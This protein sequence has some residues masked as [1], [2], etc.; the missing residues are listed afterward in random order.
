MTK[1]CKDIL[2]FA[3]SSAALCLQL[4]G[5]EWAY[6]I[7]AT[8]FAVSI[9]N[10]DLPKEIFGG[11]QQEKTENIRFKLRLYTA[12]SCGLIVI[13]G[14]LS[15]RFVKLAIMAVM[16]PESSLPW[17]LFEILV[18]SVLVLSSV[19]LPLGYFL[20]LRENDKIP[21]AMIDKFI[22]ARGFLLTYSAFLGFGG[23]L[24]V[25]FFVFLLSIIHFICRALR[26]LIS[27][28]NAE[29]IQK[30][31]TPVVWIAEI[32]KGKRGILKT[33]LKAEESIMAYWMLSILE[34]L[35]VTM[36]LNIGL[37]DYQDLK[38][39]IFLVFLLCPCIMIYY[40]IKSNWKRARSI[41]LP[42][43]LINSAFLFAFI[44]PSAMPL[45]ALPVVSD[46]KFLVLMLWNGLDVLLVANVFDAVGKNAL[47]RKDKEPTRLLADFKKYAW[48]YELL[49]V[50]AADLIL[51]GI[52]VGF[53]ALDLFR[54]LVLGLLTALASKLIL[55]IT[56]RG[57]KLV[58]SEFL[59]EFFPSTP[60]DEK[61]YIE[62]L[63]VPSLK[64]S[65]CIGSAA[66][67]IVV[68]L[69]EIF[70][71][72]SLSDL[73]FWVVLLGGP[74][75]ISVLFAIGCLKGLRRLFVSTSA[76]IKSN[77]EAVQYL[78]NTIGWGVLAF[79]IGPTVNVGSTAWKVMGNSFLS[80]LTYVVIC[81]LG[82]RILPWGVELVVFIPV[83]WFIT[84][85]IFSGFLSIAADLLRT[86][87]ASLEGILEYFILCPLC[88]SNKSVTFKIDLNGDFISCSK[89][90][91]RW[92]I[93][94]NN[95]GFRWAKLQEASANGRGR[96]LLEKKHEP[97]FWRR[98]ASGYR[99]GS[100][101]EGLETNG[102][103]P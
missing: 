70:R 22:N 98:M 53:F 62:I 88:L 44:D 67:F 5:F 82:L 17:L 34:P 11:Y 50:L 41:I 58:E 91:A 100:M 64:I 48:K 101:L 19:L 12:I 71:S 89:C 76:D 87:A 83:T 28:V 30:E 13:G 36:T 97:E 15:I 7:S 102:D 24:F 66:A 81:W 54:W 3:S 84:N 77:F 33:W 39:I 96:D 65:L 21:M 35:S 103:K 86:I 93:Q 37:M 46:P 32:E 85:V 72:L 94:C 68:F 90:G 42:V 40:G 31:T 43:A 80:C 92:Q 99:M 60:Q 95:K 59:K 14:A 79:V 49:T 2:T 47:T 8:L 61:S 75:T 26:T 38:Q 45:S 51:L 9:Y 23:S 78:R 20:S 55:D 74:T 6:I 57:D 4:L 18:A 1:P 25:S 52:V 16:G 10:Y 73:V 27:R 69:N 63:R 56:A 29:K